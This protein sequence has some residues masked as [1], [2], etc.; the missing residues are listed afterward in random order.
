MM[1]EIDAIFEYVDEHGNVL[2]VVQRLT[3]KRFRQARPNKDGGWIYNLDGVRRPVFRL[4]RILQHLEENR[5]EPIFVVEGEKDA[6]AIEKVGGTATCNPG[7]AEGGS[8][9]TPR[10]S[11]A[12]VASS[13]V[14]DRDEPGERHA[15][16]VRDSLAA[17]GVVAKTVRAVEGKDAADHLAAGR[18]L[19][20]F[21]PVEL[22]HLGK[23]R[24]RTSP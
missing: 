12:L 22:G 23:L 7:G 10:A 4:P 16:Q 5:R 24:A 3:G 20:D 19:D 2:F 15:R 14:V 8:T 17:V 21:E 13:I 6:L 1:R 11:G 18:S 9:S